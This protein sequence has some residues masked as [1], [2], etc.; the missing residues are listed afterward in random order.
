MISIREFTN[1]CGT[2]LGLGVS[3]NFSLIFENFL[4][5]LSQ[6]S[7]IRLKFADAL[8]ATQVDSFS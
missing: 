2:L 5:K 1:K 7:K 8:E 6:F 4:K 3:A